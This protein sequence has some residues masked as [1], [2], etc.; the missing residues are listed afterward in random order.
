MKGFGTVVTGTLV[1]GTIAI[2]DELMVQ[3]GG[4]L[5]KVR[6][7]QVHGRPSTQAVAGQRTAINLGGVDVGDVSRGETLLTADTLSVTRRVDAEID[8]LPSAKPLKHGARVRLHNG[9]AE[10]AGPRLDRR[11]VDRRDR[12]RQQRTGSHAARIAG[13]PDARRS[14][15]HP[16]VLAADHDRRRHRD[17]SGADAAGNPVRGRSGQ[18]RAAT[19]RR[20]TT[21]S[22]R[23]WR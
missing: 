23:S 15:H 16:R 9:T 2:D 14:L 19:D 7:V 3:P 1:A 10:V 13:G 8:L 12:A 18:S 11:G 22:A 17:R 21:A 20:A 4:R 5:V 6:G